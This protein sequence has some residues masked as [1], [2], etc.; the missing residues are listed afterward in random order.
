L[1]TA[2]R[3]FEPP[4]PCFYQQESFLSLY[5]ELKGDIRPEDFVI[6]FAVPTLN[7]LKEYHFAKKKKPSFSRVNRKFD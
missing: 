2:N 6:D 4:D 7:C 3:C 1:V 5:K